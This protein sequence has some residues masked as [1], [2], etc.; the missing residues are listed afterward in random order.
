MDQGCLPARPIA[1]IRFTDIRCSSSVSHHVFFPPW[2]RLGKKKYPATA[3][4]SVIMPSIIKSQRPGS[5]WV[6]SYL[7][8]RDRVVHTALIATM[9][10]QVRICSSLEEAAEHSSDWASKPKDH[11]TFANFSWCIPRAQQVMDTWVKTRPRARSER[12]TQGDSFSEKHGL[13]RKIQLE[14]GEHTTTG[15]TWQMRYRLSQ[16][17]IQAQV[18]EWPI[19]ERVEWAINWRGFGRRR[20]PLSK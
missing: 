12:W 7:K 9:S 3:R 2:G 4:G 20:I 17:P 1:C 14:T 8:G 6:L 11:C 13:T 19:G 5:A 15:R 16:S 18:T 10:V